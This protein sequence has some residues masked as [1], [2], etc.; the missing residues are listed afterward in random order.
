MDGISSATSALIQRFH[1]IDDGSLRHT[2]IFRPDQIGDCAVLRP[3]P[4]DEC[5]LP[6]SDLSESFV[7]GWNINLPRARIQ[8]FLSRLRPE[9]NWLELKSLFA[10]AAVHIPRGLADGLLSFIGDDAQRWLV[11]LHIALAVEFHTFRPNGL[12]VDVLD[13]GTWGPVKLAFPS[14]RCY[15][16]LTNLCT[17]SVRALER[18]AVDLREPLAESEVDATRWASLGKDAFHSLADR[19]KRISADDSKTGNRAVIETAAFAAKHVQ[20]FLPLRLYADFSIPWPDGSGDLAGDDTVRWFLAWQSFMIVLQFERP[21]ELPT[22]INV[23]RKGTNFETDNQL[24]IP[25]SEWRLRAMNYSDVCHFLASEIEA[26]L[27][28]RTVDESKAD[29]ESGGSDGNGANAEGSPQERVGGEGTLD[30]RALAVYVVN[31]KLSKKQ[32]ADQLKCNAKSLTPKRCP[33]LDSA[34]RAYRT[35]DFASGSKSSDGSIEAWE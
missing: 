6:H 35:T 1:S 31:P 18:L 10:A 13:A 3:D 28:C 5:N 15:S 7:A 20:K 11:A 2:L 23:F 24:K 21:F 22:N 30:E 14:E 16:E 26:D 12:L 32:I 33:R 34:I 19:F 29:G 8:H 25:S 4:K 17:Q 27:D 9:D